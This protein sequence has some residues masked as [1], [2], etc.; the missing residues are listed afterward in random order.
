[1]TL[2]LVSLLQKLLGLFKDVSLIKLYGVSSDTDLF[3]IW[4]SLSL[5][6]LSL[7]G[8]SLQTVINREIIKNSSSTV[9][10]TG[11]NKFCLVSIAILLA[12]QPFLPYTSA[13]NK[14]L[15]IS[16]TVIFYVVNYY[17]R[18]SY[19]VAMGLD[20]KALSI[21]LP[22]V[23]SLSFATLIYIFP[24]NSIS[25][26]IIAV[27]SSAVELILLRIILLS[28]QKKYSSKKNIRINVFPNMILDLSILSIASLMPSLYIFFEQRVIF[29]G[30]KGFLTIFYFGSKIP[31]AV[32]SVLMTVIT[33]AVFN[34]SLKTTNTRI[35]GIS[36]LKHVAL[37][38]IVAIALLFFNDYILHLY[39][40]ISNVTDQKHITL[41][42]NIFKVFCFVVPF[43]IGSLACSRFL[44]AR[45]SPK[46]YTFSLMLTGFLQLITLLILFYFA[47]KSPHVSIA[48]ASIVNFISYLIVATLYARFSRKN[49]YLNASI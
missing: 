6:P 31:I 36:I 23:N 10:L 4:A 40:Q 12:I 21:G 27:L 34:N 38:F 29:S 44:A 2:Y 1:V 22:I 35:I 3:L 13:Y 24:V 49:Q 47:A 37:S 26:Y 43:Q 16:M 41:A 18:C 33:V 5:I 28:G 11:L 9:S 14:I 17:L 32:S 7:I 46:E 45:A 8:N 30:G 15:V 39:S 25:L 20:K 19:S 42:K 48:L